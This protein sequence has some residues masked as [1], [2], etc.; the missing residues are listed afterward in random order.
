M[1]ISKPVLTLSL[2]MLFLVSGCQTAEPETQ[3]N[4]PTAEPASPTTAAAPAA[5][6]EIAALPTVAPTVPATPTAEQTAVQETETQADTP[7]PPPTATPTETPIPINPVNSISL[8]PVLQ[9]VFTQPLY[10]TNAGDG[11]LFVVE[12]AGVIR[13]V[14]QGQLLD[15]PFLDIRDR[16][17]SAQLEQGL[18][19]LAFHPD[20]ASNGAFFV[21]YT[22]RSGNSQISRFMV[23]Q[24]DANLA[25]PESETLLLSYQQP[26]P[27]HNGGQVAFGPDGYLYI[28]VGDGGSANDPL[29]NGQNPATILGT[30]LRLDVNQLDVTYQIPPTNPFVGSDDRLNE[31]WAWGLRN[32]WRFS[33]DRLTGDLFVA[34]VGQNLWEEVD[35]QP[36]TSQGGE[37]YGWNILEGTH[38]FASDPC[39]PTGMVAPIFEYSHSEGCSVTGG[40]IYRGEEFMDLYGNYFVADY[41]QGTIWRLV[42]EE[43]GEWSSAVVLDTPYVISSFG[44]DA[45]GELYILDHAGGSLFRILP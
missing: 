42:A 35:F 14:D 13:I 2:I 21:N 27:N 32:P 30:L 40:Y 23:S 31:I 22:D 6:A 34:D 9:G 36:A 8:E 43:S 45:D 25:D 44:E 4:Q 3:E 24:G 33:F 11:R 18:L 39:D 15:T 29:D 28:G 1:N 12:Q 41:C 19:G 10:L 5:T 16:V 38:C 17:G 20:Y 37:N 7:T 26:Y